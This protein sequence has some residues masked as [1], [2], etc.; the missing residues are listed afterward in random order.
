VAGS[1]TVTFGFRRRWR[2]PS[3]ARQRTEHEVSSRRSRGT[4]RS[5]RRAGRGG[6][7][8]PTASPSNLAPARFHG[9]CCP[10]KATASSAE[11]REER[12]WGEGANGQQR[13]ALERVRGSIWPAWSRC[14]V[15][16]EGD[17]WEM[18]AVLLMRRCE[19]VPVLGLARAA[20]H[21]LRLD[22]VGFRS[23]ASETARGAA[24]QVS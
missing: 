22:T 10:G 15:H 12:E 19:L 21:C 20:V 8:R 2:R 9:L 11:L 23:W 4:R 17:D 24:C 3:S 18:Q 5:R 14:R 1:S 13:K 7:C 6:R 16:L